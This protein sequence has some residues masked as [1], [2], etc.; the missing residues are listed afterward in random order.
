MR[1]ERGMTEDSYTIRI[2][3]DGRSPKAIQIKPF[4]NRLVFSSDS[5]EMQRERDRGG[6]SYSRQWGSSSRTIRL[7]GDADATGLVRSDGE[8]VID[9]SI[10]RMS[11]SR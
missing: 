5:L 10:P 6:Y 1:M 8:D 11:Y 3:L 4:R 2:Y 9:I 7:P